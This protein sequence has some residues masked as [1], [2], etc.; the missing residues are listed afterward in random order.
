MSHEV[1]CGVIGDRTFF[2]TWC[3]VGQHVPHTLVRRQRMAVKTMSI[4]GG[5]KVASEHNMIIGC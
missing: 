1:D 5:F 4:F 3:G 2:M